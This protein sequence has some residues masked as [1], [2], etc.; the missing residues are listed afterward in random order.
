MSTWIT[1]SV[2]QLE[3]DYPEVSD[4]PM[5]LYILR[6]RDR[7]A[8]IDTG[9]VSTYR[10][11]LA[12]QLAEERMD[13]REV[14]AIINTHGHPDHFG[15]NASWLEASSDAQILAPLADAPWVEDH[16]RHWNELWDSFPG[17]LSW[18]AAMKTSVLEDFCGPNT[19]VDVFVRDGTEIDLGGR[20]VRAIRTGAHSPDH[21]AYWD[22]KDRLLFS[23]DVVQGNGAPFLS[24]LVNLAPLYSDPEEYRRGLG[25][26]A[27]HDF[28]WLIP[29][30]AQ[31]LSADAGQKLLRES[32]A[33]VDRVDR[34]LDEI[35]AVG[36]PLTIA[37]V[38]GEI[39]TRLGN[40]GGVSLQTATVAQA[41][42]IERLR[43]KSLRSEW[44]MSSATGGDGMS[45]Q[46][47]G[48]AEGI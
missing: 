43:A 17:C 45:E 22:E 28:E 42:L 47:H 25:V 29:S 37:S 40:F 5:W 4:F 13:S 39:G 24:G 2:L 16:E 23:G 41:H 15:G 26:L 8:I 12:P 6:G 11:T 33:Y 38:A 1:D 46:N 44:L 7:S 21:M 31:P 30:H 20:V 19:P 48:R 36:A 27:R 34:L 9:V 10:M 35:D 3:T 18:E 32:I 14:T